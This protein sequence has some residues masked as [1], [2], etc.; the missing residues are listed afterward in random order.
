M[1]RHCCDNGCTSGMDTRHRVL[2]PL[3]HAFDCH[4]ANP[5]PRSPPARIVDDEKKLPFLPVLH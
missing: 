5:I 1:T 2:L 3:R 4:I